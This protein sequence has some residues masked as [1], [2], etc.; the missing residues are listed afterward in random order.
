MAIDFPSSPTNGQ[1]YGN[2]IYD[3]SIT[4][5]R[6]VN[7][8][9]GIGTLNAMGLKNIVPSSVSVASGSASVNGNGTITVNGATNL[10]IN[11]C[12][13]ATYK[14]YKMIVTL[15]ASGTTTIQS[16]LRN[17]GGLSSSNYTFR[18]IAVSAGTFGTAGT[19]SFEHTAYTNQDTA[20]AEFLNPFL[21]STTQCTNFAIEV[22]TSY[23]GM[24]MNTNATSYNSIDLF[25][26][27]GEAFS[28]TIQFYGYNG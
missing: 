12:F 5:W 10:T 7:T 17:S 11:D 9:T 6:N 18:Y 24:G 19:T 25:K 3:S 27:N 13:S 2:W 8:D 28:A 22:N 16:R 14:S 15:T 23:I 4:A 21:A 1:V 26:G 20:S